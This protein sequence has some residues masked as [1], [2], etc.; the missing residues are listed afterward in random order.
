MKLRRSDLFVENKTHNHI[1]PHSADLFVKTKLKNN[2]KLRRSDLF[3]E[4]ELE[5]ILNQ[6]MANYF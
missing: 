1:K 3:V 5:I 4:I 6:I 2:M